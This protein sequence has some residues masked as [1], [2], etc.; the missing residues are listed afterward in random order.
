MY[1]IPLDS[2]FFVLILH[3]S[4]CFIK[5]FKHIKKLFSSTS[6]FRFSIV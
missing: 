5:N 4:I 2:L 6:L 3:F 1:L